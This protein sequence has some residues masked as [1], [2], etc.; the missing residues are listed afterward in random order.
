MNNTRRA[1]S[2]ATFPPVYLCA[3]CGARVVEDPCGVCATCEA[4][5]AARERVISPKAFAAFLEVLIAVAMVALGLVVAR[6]L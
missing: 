2:G 1:I 3:R 4:M 5:P 6:F